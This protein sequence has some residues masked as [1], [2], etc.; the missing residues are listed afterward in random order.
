VYGMPADSC[1]MRATIASVGQRTFPMQMSWMSAGDIAL[2]IG[3]FAKHPLNA[4]ERRVD[5][6]TFAR[7]PLLARQSG[8]RT[9][10]TITTSLGFL[11]VTGGVI[12]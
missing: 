9:A 10:L 12:L 4:V 8:V 1:A 2:L 11:G 7:A 6:A 3:I 5:G